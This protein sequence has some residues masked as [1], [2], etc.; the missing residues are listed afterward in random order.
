MTI[1]NTRVVSRLSCG[2]ALTLGGLVAAMS[3]GANPA[4]AATELTHVAEADSGNYATVEVASGSELAG[5]Q[6]SVLI[7]EDDANEA[8][9]ATEDIVFI[10]Q[11]TLDEVGSV[12]FRVQL[13]TDDLTAYDIVLNTDGDTVRYVEPLA[14]EDDTDPLPTD[15]TTPPTDAPGNEDATAD[16]GAGSGS[17][18]N[19]D[20]SAGANNGANGA[21]TA[22]GTTDDPTS[23]EPGSPDGTGSADGTDDD[24]LASTGA[25]FIGGVVI[26][27]LAGAA[28]LTLLLRRRREA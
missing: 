5:A 23:T 3:L 19:G 4:L 28:G 27:A 26:A 18:A 12:S 14:G 20:D 8:A 1:S 13:P 11:L 22:E 16:S 10:E 21:G 7:M 17:V 9:P 2:A 24:G 25:T 6:L 15:P